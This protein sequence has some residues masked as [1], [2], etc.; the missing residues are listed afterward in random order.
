MNRAHEP[1][2]EVVKWLYSEWEGHGWHGNTPGGKRYLPVI[3]RGEREYAPPTFWS[4]Y[5]HTHT[6]REKRS[7]LTLYKKA[8][9]FI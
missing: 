9:V 8:T 2:L 4:I 7:H 3:D 6:H 1:C 5:T